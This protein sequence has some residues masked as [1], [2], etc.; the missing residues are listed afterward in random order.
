MRSTLNLF[1]L[2]AERLEKQFPDAKP[3][4]SESEAIIEANRCLYCYD[5]PCIEACPTDIDIPSFIKKI[6]TN[7]LLGSAKTILS[8][9]A[10]GCSCGKVC[11]VEVLCV[12]ACVLNKLNKSPIQ[13]GKLQYFA[14]EKIVLNSNFKDNN[15]FPITRS[16]DKKVALIGA[17]P[18]S[19]SCAFYLAINGVR[20][21]IF[22]KSDIPGGL[23]TAGIAPYKLQSEDA[24]KEINWIIQHAID[25]QTGVEIGK[26]IT[27]DKLQKEYDAVFVGVGMGQDIDL[28]IHDNC[29]SLVL[30]ATELIEKIKNSD[31]FKLPKNVNDVIVIGGGNTAIDISRELAMLG[32]QNVKIVYRRTEQEMKGFAHELAGAREFGVRLVENTKPIEIIKSGTQKLKLR[33][34]STIDNG[35]TEFLC[36]WVVMA[37]GQKKN[38]KQL[39]PELK[40]DDT[41]CPIVNPLT[42]KTNLQD[43]YAGGDCVNGGKEVVNAVADGKNAAFAML[44]SWGLSNK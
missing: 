2:P 29:S 23:N 40:L 14:T 4:L 7:N 10:L 31:N 12:G 15:I 44:K 13:I 6:S 25:L 28:N 33:A 18:A 38:I 37:I 3:K 9:N 16:S 30:G 43:V 27:F 5:A 26:K 21:V 32:V 20:A 42:Q 41:D 1:G 36:D 11:S 17:G 35:S 8:A 19:L 39:I 24:L 34:S 22:E